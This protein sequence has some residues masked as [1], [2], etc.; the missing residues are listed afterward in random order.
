MIVITR[1]NFKFSTILI[2]K[3]ELYVLSFNMYN[4]LYK[5]TLI[6]VNIRI[7]M[8][9]FHNININNK[10]FVSLELTLKTVK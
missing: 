8:T 7:G 1:I 4:Y 5:L 6:K 9:S 10:I 2:K 3:L